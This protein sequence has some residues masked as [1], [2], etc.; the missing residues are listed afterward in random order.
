[1]NNSSNIF[2]ESQNPETIVSKIKKGEWIDILNSL[3]IVNDNI[4]ILDYIFFKYFA[5]KE[6][7]DML[8]NHIMTRINTIL[9]T[10][11]TFIIHINVKSLTLI[12]IEKHLN[13]LQTF[14][15]SISEIYSTKMLRCYVY[16]S[17]Y[18]FSKLINLLSMFIDPKTKQKIEVV[19]K[20]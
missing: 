19:S 9:K 20:I 7:Y 16:N 17:T 8:T 10:Y 4:L 12:D 18:V 3:C 11:D 15:L 14:S 13:F 6:T 1:M 2:F 5:S